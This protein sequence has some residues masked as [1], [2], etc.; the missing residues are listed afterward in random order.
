MFSQDWAETKHIPV[1]VGSLAPTF[2]VGANLPQGQEKA[3][4]GFLKANKDMFAWSTSNLLGLPRDVIENHLMV[5]PNARP[6]K[7]KARRQGPEKQEYI[8]QEV[9]KLKEAGVIREVR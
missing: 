6:V 9:H 2:T 4:V 3:L 1:D 7:Q 8:A 5:W